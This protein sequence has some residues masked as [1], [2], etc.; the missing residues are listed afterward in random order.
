[1]EGVRVSI[2]IALL[3]NTAVVSA[4]NA[5]GR[6]FHNE[7]ERLA[8]WKAVEM[9]FHSTGLSARERQ[10]VEKLVEACR[11]LDDVFWRQS[12]LGG[13]ALYKGTR[14][15]TLKDLLG[16]MGSRWDLLDQNRPFI[17]EEPMFPGHEFY[18]DDLTPAALDQYLQKHPEDR[19]AIYNPYTVVKW[20]GDRLVAVPY[21]EEYK[22]F[23]Q[24]MAKALGDAAALSDDAA[25][26]S[27][28]RMRA[29]ALLTDDYY[30]S[31][32]A[33]L[34]L[35]DPKF[36]VIFAPYETYLD[37]LLGVKTS[38]G[39]AILI[40]NQEESRKLALYQKY[41]PDIQDALP[42][43]AADRPSERGRV[44]PMEVMDAPF[45]AGDLR[46]GYQAVAD[47]L[48]ND[49]RVHHE[50]GSKKIFFKNFM[51]VRVTGIVLPLAKRMIE[52]GQ[53]EKVSAEG[54]LTA[55]VMHEIA[56]GLG[57]SFARN[58][59]Q[60]VD[61]GAALGPVSSG[62]EEAKA[63]AVGMFG[64]AWLVDHGVLPKNRL[65]EYYV[66][67]VADFFR[68]LRFGAG[69]AHGRAE[70]MEF[71]YLLEQRA[72]ARVNGR[73]AIDYA[74]MPAALAQLS[75]EL[76]ETEATGDRARAEAWFAR[77]D[78]MPAELRTALAA[79]ADI[80][81]DIRP[82]FSFPDKVE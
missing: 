58:N 18:P 29:A 71:N 44:T 43:E 31:D 66:S 41:V 77:Y 16:I 33:W 3:A 81:V 40:R 82:T 54:Y 30:R 4:Q 7:A 38:Y 79:T 39:A 35:K 52:P 51:D 78:K 60:Q 63:D 46:Y 6:P 1:M 45:R 13:L 74:R 80:P 14:S 65:E 68:A 69:E 42:L 19:A 10:L 5:G 73:Y 15:Q 36:D 21:H 32:L 11:L 50:K 24:P 53:A 64:L 27:F 9:P 23:L 37:D 34:D 56:H 72:L 61:I 47:N 59:G 17:G 8:R 48:P 20:K 26:A 70:M 76:L 25:F 62:L 57:P 12:D 49:P 28:L 67:F 55:T 75:R 22:Q 2:L